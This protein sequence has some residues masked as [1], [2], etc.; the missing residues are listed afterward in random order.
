MHLKNVLVF[1]VGNTGS[2]QN[3]F[4][5]VDI[6]ESVDEEVA[7]G[8]GSDVLANTTWCLAA[9]SLFLFLSA[10]LEC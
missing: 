8:A 7:A 6:T 5:V 2:V 3:G 1:T 9:R 4:E 10:G